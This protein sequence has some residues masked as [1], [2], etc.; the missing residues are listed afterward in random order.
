MAKVLFASLLLLLA[1]LGA[2]SVAAKPTTGEGGVRIRNNYD[3]VVLGG[4]TA[5]SA[6]AARLAENPRH[7]VLLVERGEDRTD[8]PTV[9]VPTMNSVIPPVPLEVLPVEH[10]HTIETLLARQ[11][12]P[13]VVPRALGGGPAVSG[14][15]WGRGGPQAYNEW[16]E[17]VGDDS[18]RYEALLPFFKKSERVKPEDSPSPDRGRDGPIDVVF[19]D[20]ND[21]AIADLAAK[22]SEV[23]GVP[24][25]NDYCTS[26]GQLGIWPMQR[27]LGW[28]PVCSSFSG[29]CQ[30]QSAY[31][32]YIKNG[33]SRPNLHVLPKTTALNLIYGRSRPGENAKVVGARVL[34][35]GT[36]LLEIRAKKEVIVSLG[37]VNS[38]KFLM[39]SGIGDPSDLT[40]HGIEPVVSLPGV[41]Q[42][43]Q[44]HA[45]FSFA[46]SVPS[47]PSLP[48]PSA[49]RVAFLA[50]GHHEDFVDIEV[51]WTLF[52]GNRLVGYI[53]QL[54]GAQV[55]EIKLRTSEPTDRVDMKLNL[56]VN[57]L[58]PMI[59]AF[60]KVRE[61]MAEFP[62]AVEISATTAIP[63]GATDAQFRTWLSS[64]VGA[65]YHMAGTC[66]MGANN[67][68]QAVVDSEFRVFGVDNLRVVDCSVMPV[69]VPTHPSA[70]SMMLAERCA[71]FIKEDH[72]R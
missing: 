13:T 21:T 31:S 15:F 20:P 68:A 44:D 70:T 8:D 34:V 29:P 59:W 62:G 60:R 53:V 66:K 71:A 11:S 10:F 65:W 69:V 3:F 9:A 5:G 24:E 6:V 32:E 26:E 19:L 43:L 40:P 12:T 14:S 64:N 28:D 36:T 50:S 17:L 27:S 37:P 61:W 7:T 52:P 49:V 48:A 67:D 58:D 45:V 30:R 54:R 41:G 55:G 33:P 22:Q 47:T 16:A 51:A 18:L 2:G 72:P 25:R 4:G 1:V 63:Q 46:Y 42:N 23:F 38:P 35:D 56:D 57:N 39:L